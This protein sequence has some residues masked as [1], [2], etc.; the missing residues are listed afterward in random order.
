MSKGIAKKQV[1]EAVLAGVEQASVDY[2]D[3]SGWSSLWYAPEYFLTVS[4]ATQISS[5]GSC[6]LTLEDSVRDTMKSAGANG[7]GRPSKGLRKNGRFDIVLWW[8]SD[9][10]RA[11]IEV[12]HALLSPNEVFEKDIIRIRDLLSASQR[13]EGDLQFG[14]LAFWTW[15]DAKKTDQESIGKRIKG[16]TKALQ[17]AASRL[18]GEDF[19]VSLHR[20]IHE[21]SGGNWGW[22]AVLLAI[23]PKTRRDQ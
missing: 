14:G 6:Y 15:V 7:R 17:E 18:V 4:I 12:K 11:V 9:T 8:Q 19:I 16:N 1:F 22:A 3:M 13:T 5:L 23:E 20:N 10:P 2:A 21:G